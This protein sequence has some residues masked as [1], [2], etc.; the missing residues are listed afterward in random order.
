MTSTQ[1]SVLIVG[2]GSIGER[3]LRCFQATGRANV[4]FVEINDSLRE[5]IAQ[6][7]GVRGYAD[8]RHAIETERPAAAVV[9]T[10]ANHHIEIAITLAEAVIHLLI[11]KPLSTRVEGV[12]RLARV[13]GERGVVV[14]VAYVYRCFPALAAVRDVLLSGRFGKPVEL[15]AVCGQNFPTYRP[16]YRSTYY[17]NHATGGGAIQDALTHVLNAG[18][19]LLGPIDRL[20]ADAAHQV[21]DGVDVEDTV[22]LLARHGDVLGSYSLNQHQ[23]PNEFTLTVICERGTVRWESHAQRW[24]W[25][26]EPDESWHDEPYEPQPRDA[27]FVTQANRFLDAVEGQSS[28][29]CS[30]EEGEQTLRVNLAALAS[31]EQGGWQTIGDSQAAAST[32]PTIQQ[33][34]DLTGRVALVTGGCGHLGS[35]MCRALAEA[36]ASV[37]V[38]SRDASK[39]SRLA[40][41]LP[42]R[43]AARHHGIELDH[44][45]PDSLA[46]SFQTAVSLAGSVDVLVNNGHA[47]VAADWNSVTAEEFSRQLGN[48]TG[49]FV[50]SRLLRDYAVERQVSA[51]IILLGSMYGVVGSYPEAYSGICSASPVAY[52]ALKGSIV[53]M[54]RHL[55]VYWANDRVRVN[56]LSPGPF[57]GPHAPGEMVE[58][59]AAKSPMGRMGSPQELKGA[60]VFLASDASSYV[61]GQ[62]LIV[63]GGRTAW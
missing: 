47:A 53:Q 31:V 41:S 37:V 56:C 46:A 39:A 30:L 5:T 50:L 4:S 12:E 40:E 9:A 14:G 44:M 8:L 27:A 17:T 59:L 11:E 45:Q 52:H 34:F 36:G 18:E 58:R 33:L 38:T 60:L 21:L 42:R 15:V 32:E 3:H 35:A 2:V 1:T 43:G 63:D 48:A 28:L 23:A 24:R 26:I 22:H 6:R 25:V 19:W 16:A 55:A 7:Y 62:N 61:T 49:Y 20:V 10:P 51:S 13:A 54:T 29:L 57:P